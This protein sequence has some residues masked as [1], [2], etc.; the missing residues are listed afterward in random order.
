VVTVGLVPCFAAMNA[1]AQFFQQILLDIGFKA[2]DV[3][4]GYNFYVID[5]RHFVSILDVSKLIKLGELL[6]SR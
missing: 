4:F 3:S 6:A 5:R 1:R 2:D